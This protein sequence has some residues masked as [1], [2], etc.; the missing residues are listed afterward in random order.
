V[1]LAESNHVVHVPLWFLV[2]PSVL[3]K[4]SGC[5]VSTLAVPIT[6]VLIGHQQLPWAGSMQV[7]SQRALEG[8]RTYVYKPGGYTWL[9]HAHTPLWNCESRL[10]ICFRLGPVDTSCLAPHIYLS[11]A[12]F[13]DR[14][15][16]KAT[17]V[18]C[19]ELDH[20]QWSPRHVLGILC[21]VVHAAGVCG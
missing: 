19:P 9:D 16:V 12:C 20:T 2:G 11:M 17:D 3:H 21:D 4:K 8:L 1:A 13:L 14:D 15:D 18:A 7:L 6:E 5:N 10:I